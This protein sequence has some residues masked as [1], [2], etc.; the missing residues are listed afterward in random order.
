M[1][2]VYLNWFTCAYSHI[3]M[4]TSAV[5]MGL[6]SQSE[7]IS[8]IPHCAVLYAAIRPAVPDSKRDLASGTNVCPHSCNIIVVLDF[9][10]FI[11]SADSWTG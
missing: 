3:V 9:E 6:Y 7:L 1:S 4:L 10:L 2:T 5:I 8:D 11:A